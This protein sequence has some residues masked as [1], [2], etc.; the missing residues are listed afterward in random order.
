MRLGENTGPR[1]L[2]ELLDRATLGARVLT[3]T[4]E[5]RDLQLRFSALEGRFAAMESR[6]SA[7]E[8][9]LGAIERRLDVQ[10]ERM[11]AMLAVI[12]RIAERLD[13][14]AEPPSG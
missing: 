11:S 13:R 1:Q 10:E 4:G 7:M 12:V 5:V 3:L 14:T 8:I 6:F 9:R 2:D